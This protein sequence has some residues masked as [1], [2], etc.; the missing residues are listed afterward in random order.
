[1]H[2]ILERQIQKYFPDQS[3]LPTDLLPF[4]QSVSET[5]DHADQ[6]RLLIERSLELSSAEL[7]QLNTQLRSEKNI[8]QKKV[9]ERTQQLV[10]EQAKLQASINSLS[11]GYIMIDLN[12]AVLTINKA[13]EEILFLEKAGVS[14]NLKIPTDR[15]V[16]R[17][18]QQRLT[19]ID[20]HS[21]IT[22]CI[23]NKKI[24]NMDDI[25]F[26]SRYLRILL[27]PISVNALE[28]TIGIVIL[29]EDI[30]E[31]K[32]MQRSKDEFFSI[33]SHELRTPL[34]AIRSTAELIE[35]IY[36]DILADARL[37][38]M[39]GTIKLSSI[40]L[41][42]IVNEFLDTSRLEQ[43][44]IVFKKEVVNIIELV[45][46]IIA[47]MGSIAEQKHIYLA[48]TNIEPI[49]YVLADKDRVKQVLVNLIGNALKFTEQGS[50]LVSISPMQD[51][52]KIFITD[53]GKGISEL[54]RRL[55]FRKFQQAG[56]DL[57]VR[58]T[59]KGTGLGLYISKIMIE[60][61]GGKIMLEDSEVNKGTTFSCT[62][63]STIAPQ[64][65]STS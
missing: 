61:M 5:Y 31:A 50:V 20:L 53:T 47:E 27:S 63:P 29:I 43:G 32:I 26:H 37:K 36:K 60:K 48:L 45:K 64:I 2:K 58:D 46:E 39:I 12:E 28:E 8:V 3:N 1:M 41:T 51:L 9:D 40:R 23:T 44:R 49:I 34:T 21:L 16:V 62:L 33:A 18:I 30:T 22:E 25:V 55:L 13:A 35:M 15:Y 56:D 6:D 57:Y 19:S 7:T 4:L 65:G 17:D 10:E 42:E 52:T 59:T 54:N 38:K 24:I 14:D 11:I